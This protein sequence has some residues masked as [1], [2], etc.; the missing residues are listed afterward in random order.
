MPQQPTPYV[1]NQFNQ[2]LKTEYTGLN[3]PENA[4]FDTEN[5]VFNRIGNTTRRPGINYELNHVAV[6][7]TPAIPTGGAINTYYWKNVGGD[8]TTQVLVAQHK[9]KLFFYKASAATIANPLSTQLLG[10][11]G[12]A[13]VDISSFVAT[14]GTY[15][16]TKEC[17][18][19]DGNGYLFV[20]HPSC[21][22][23]YVVY[24]FGSPDTVSGKLITIKIRDFTGFVEN[25]VED[26]YRP[27][28]L[29]VEH[30]YNLQNQGWINSPAWSA[31]STTSNDTSLSPPNKTWIIQTGLTISAGQTVSITVNHSGLGSII[32][33]G[34]VV[35]Y[36]NGTGAL[37]VTVTGSPGTAGPFTD[38]T[39]QSITTSFVTSWFASQ[40][41]YPSNSDVWWTFKN[42]SG[43][44][45]VTTIPNIVLANSPAPKGFY[46]LDAFNQQR[47]ALSGIAGLTSITTTTRP[48]TTCW[49]AGRVWYAGT[50]AQQNATGDA[51]NYTWTENIYYS[52]IIERENQFGR[53]YQTNDP[54]SE[55]LF[56]LLPTDGGTLK[57]QGC[58]SIYKLF[59]IQN[60]L[61]IFAANGIWFITGSQGIGFS[62]NDFVVVRVSS[63]ASISGTSFV[64]V[65]GMPMWWNEEGI[66]TITTSNEATPYGPSRGAVGGNVG[67]MATPLTYT[68]IQSFYDEIPYTSK[69]YVRGS[70]DPIN[71]LVKWVFLSTEATNITNR[72]QF[73]SV[74]VL[75]T[76]TQAFYPWNITTTAGAPKIAGV[77]FVYGVGGSTKPDSIMKYYT[78]GPVTSPPTFTYTFAEEND[79]TN[80]V[81]WHGSGTD[82]NFSSFFI[83]G[84]GIKG[85][86]QHKFQLEYLYLYLNNTV[87]CS[88]RLQ[89]IWDY[90][91]SGNSGKYSSLERV[92]IDES[93]SNFSVVHRR[94]RLRGRGL[95]LQFRVVSVDRA[96]FDIIGWSADAK[97][98]TGV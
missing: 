12:T 20:V 2:G 41:N 13:I 46:I 42:T 48:K 32:I 3:F 55:N 6:V 65:Q 96:P 70:F 67:L 53:C 57:I 50:D 86:A 89:A 26:N 82:Y 87:N 54:T 34:V 29:S 5:C 39:F 10:N 52:Q 9:D 77:N 72:Y 22:P 68:S 49:F 4:A 69:Q 35:S 98:N 94:H 81:D 47:S 58:G 28:A 92:D 36:N 31:T 40:K 90:A 27:P 64:D 1:M 44:F 88:Y 30:Q 23:F 17:Q 37:V 25:S 71:W 62:A 83:T 19:S 14:G 15:D 11:T 60:G 97:V 21:D 43:A 24:T 91:I 85:M 76:I 84:Y 75:N 56:D 93:T 61:M 18:F 74:L 16:N 38:W 79:E 95:C 8:G 33:S 59:P 80:W 78:Y 45:D 63:I 51:P 73:D 66:Y 7:T